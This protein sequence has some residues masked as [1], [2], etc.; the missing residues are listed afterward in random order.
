MPDRRDQP[1]R[2]RRSRTPSP[3][4]ASRAARSRPRRAQRHPARPRARLIRRRDRLGHHGGQGTARGHRRASTPTTLLAPRHRAGGASRQRRARARSAGSPSPGRRPRARS[5]RSSSCTAASRRSS[6]CPSRRCRP[7]SPAACSPESVPHEDAI[8]NVSRSALLVAALIQSP[9]LLLA[10]TEDRLHQNYRASAMPE[11]DALIRVLRAARTRRG[12]LRGRPV[13]ARARERP[14]SAARRGRARRA[15][16]PHSVAGLM[17]AVDFKGA[18]VILAPGR[19][20]GLASSCPQVQ[21]APFFASR[22][23]PRS[24][25]PSHDSRATTSSPPGRN[26]VPGPG[27]ESQ[28]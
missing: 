28:S 16:T 11:T 4:T 3:P 2:A 20:A 18:T 10:A 22:P 13:G 8:F 26:S 14:G 1:R 21:S 15:N 17:L 24:G 23:I 19:S 6:P 9:E 25:R 7:R 5:T 27:K 12:R